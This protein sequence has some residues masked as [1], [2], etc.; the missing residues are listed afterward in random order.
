ME[1]PNFNIYILN[2]GYVA[3]RDN[4]RE[5]EKVAK[6]YGV[7]CFTRRK[8]GGAK[9]GN[10]NYALKKTKE[11][12]FV[13]FDTDHIPKKH[14]LRRMMGYFADEKMGFVQS[15]QFY[16]NH[17][18]NLVTGGAWE[19]QALFFGAICKGKDAAGSAF[20]C[21]TNMALRREAVLQAGGMNEESIAEDFLTS[22]YIHK[23]G[24]KSVYVDEVLAEGL[25]PEDFLSYYK[26]QFRW[27]RGSLEVVFLHNPLLMRGLTFNQRFQYLSSASFYLSGIFVAINALLPLIFLF[28]GLEP[29]KIS[30]M[31]LAIVFIPYIFIV[32]YT[33]Q[34]TSN[35]AYTFRAI[36]FSLGAFPLHI[37]AVWQILTGK[38]VGFVVTSKKQLSGNHIYLARPHMAYIALVLIGAVI[39]FMRDGFAASVISNLAWGITYIVLFIPFILAAAENN[40]GEETELTVAKEKA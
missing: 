34:L 39:A 23:N 13:V 32:L 36:S 16:K 30:T 24:W 2:D 35:Y 14:F 12:F 5:A 33:L 4:W 27:A 22:L 1:Y 18:L 31:T 25:A 11:P 6:R 29:L 7:T 37:K 3:K 28:T 17:E 9:A 20:M 19:Q 26:Q 40:K 10:I 15:P 21:G 38:K 8:P